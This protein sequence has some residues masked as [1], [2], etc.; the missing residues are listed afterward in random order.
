MV[1]RRRRGTAIVDTPN[2]ILV[3]S[4]GRTYLL[5]GGGARSH[6]SRR[7]AAIRELR[8]ETGLEAIDCC[9]LF[10]Y[11][12]KIHKDSKGGLFRDAHKVFLV[13]SNG[14]AEPKREIKRLAYFTGARGSNVNV[15]Y[16]TRR[17]IEKYYEIKNSKPEYV[18][19]KCLHCG[20]ALNVIGLSASIKC[21]YCGTVYHRKGRVHE[22]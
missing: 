2:G 18:Q 9:Y 19:L 13:K 14:V 20:A 5:P 10:E 1:Y 22:N 16:T 7:S 8:E 21:E 11:R 17:I 12:G 4:Q 15:S 3:T 6:E